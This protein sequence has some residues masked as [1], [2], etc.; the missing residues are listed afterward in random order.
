MNFFSE[1][2]PAQSH[3]TRD[4]FAINLI[5]SVL[6]KRLIFVGIVLE[7]KFSANWKLRVNRRKPSAFKVTV[8][9][10]GSL[11]SKRCSASGLNC[12][13]LNFY[14]KLKLIEL[15][16]Q[17]YQ[18]FWNKMNCR[19]FH[20]LW[21]RVPESPFQ[22]YKSKR[23]FSFANLI[24]SSVSGP[25]ALKKRCLRFAMLSFSEKLWNVFEIAIRKCEALR[26]KIFRNEKFADRFLLFIC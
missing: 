18:K 12:R 15:A 25:K 6:Y 14:I 21:M 17:L 19:I 9:L 2:R 16:I 1:N 4:S 11:A 20:D 5:I 8:Y 13:Y 3:S 23:I 10:Q 26:G 22:S 7:F 24:C